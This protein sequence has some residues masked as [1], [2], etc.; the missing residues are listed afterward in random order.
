MVPIK[1]GSS[2][3]APL[4]RKRRSSAPNN[5]D[6]HSSTSDNDFS[7]SDNDFST[8]DNDYSTS[9]N[10]SSTIDNDSSPSDNDDDVSEYLPNRDDDPIQYHGWGEEETNTHENVSKLIGGIEENIRDGLSLQSC[11]EISTDCDAFSLL[12]VIDEEKKITPLTKN[13][14]IHLLSIFGTRWTPITIP[15]AP[16]AMHTNFR[17]RKDSMFGSQHVKMTCESNLEE[18][19]CFLVNNEALIIDTPVKI[20]VHQ[21]FRDSLVNGFNEK[22][23]P[24]ELS[25]NKGICIDPYK[26][27]ALPNYFDTLNII[28]DNCYDPRTKKH[29][30]HIGDLG[31]RHPV[32]KEDDDGFLQVMFERIHQLRELKTV[33]VEVCQ[34]DIAFNIKLGKKLIRW[35]PARN[36]QKEHSSTFFNY[37]N[38]SVFP[39]HNVES[40]GEFPNDKDQKGT[41]QFKHRN[42]GID[43]EKI[44]LV[45]EDEEHKSILSQIYLKR[46]KQEEGTRMQEEE[47]EGTRMQE[48]EGTRMH[49]EEEEGTRMLEEEQEHTREQENEEGARMQE[50]EETG[51]FTICSNIYDLH[52]I[53]FYSTVIHSLPTQTQYKF[54]KDGRDFQHIPKY[55]IRRIKDLLSAIMDFGFKGI[56]QI[57]NHGV[58]GRIEFSVRPTSHSRDLRLNGHL[59]DFLSIMFHSSIGIRSKELVALDYL[60]HEPVTETIYSLVMSVKGALVCRDSTTFDVFWK[61]HPNRCVWLTAMISLILTLSGYAHPCKTRFVRQW[62]K[63]EGMYD[64]MGVK[65]KIQEGELL[66][67]ESVQLVQQNQ[68]H[69]HVWITL[70]FILQ[71]INVSQQGIDQMYN[72]ISGHTSVGSTFRNLRLEDNLKLAE[73]ML[74]KIIPAIQNLIDQK[75]GDEGSDGE[76]QEYTQ[77]HDHMDFEDDQDF[78]DEF[79]DSVHDYPNSSFIPACD[80]A[81][82]LITQ[83]SPNLCPKVKSFMKNQPTQ[84]PIESVMS[85]LA[86]FSESLSPGAPG[87]MNRMCNFIGEVFPKTELKNYSHGNDLLYVD[88]Y[89]AATILDLDTQ[90]LRMTEIVMK[91]CEHSLFPCI[92]VKYNLSLLQEEEIESRRR[93]LLSLQNHVH[94]S[95]LRSDL[96]GHK[97]IRRHGENVDVY[98][99]E[100]EKVTQE[101]VIVNNTLSDTADSEF[102]YEN[103]SI[104]TSTLP[105]LTK[106]FND[107]GTPIQSILASSRLKFIQDLCDKFIHPTGMNHPHFNRYLTV[108][109]LI[110]AIREKKVKQPTIIQIFMACAAYHRQNNIAYADIPNAKFILFLYNLHTDKVILI[111]RTIPEGSIILPKVECIHVEKKTHNNVQVSQ[112]VLSNGSKEVCLLEDSARME[113]RNITTR[114]PRLREN[115]DK[116]PHKTKSFGTAITSILHSM[117]PLHHVSGGDDEFDHISNLV[118]EAAGIGSELNDMFDNSLISV[119]NKGKV[120]TWDD[121]ANLLPKYQG[122]KKINAST[123][124]QEK[125]THT[126]LTASIICFKYK[127]CIAIYCGATRSNDAETHFIYFHP[128]KRKVCL[129]EEK[130]FWFLVYHP[131]FIYIR[132]LKNEFQYWDADQKHRLQ[133]TRKNFFCYSA[134]HH[135]LMIRTRTKY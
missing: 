73:H 24:V 82:E 63:K 131:Q 46:E 95:T 71:E 59:V 34:L 5:D 93:I 86:E 88:L 106:L 42:W 115:Q 76:N 111:P 85:I 94:V 10:D 50:E 56:T 84:D 133:T 65:K 54:P 23:F 18:E 27:R 29:I 104:H 8:S 105:A 31:T 30:I 99:P 4:P 130:G 19:N 61:K 110:N 74:A 117:D 64:P 17:N 52:S 38:L 9:D 3:P 132:F 80:N 120:Q 21:N 33:T 90:H 135:T 25:S 62:M 98:I 134:K 114:H 7:T 60:D 119:L 123:E 108:E 70:L 28:L 11:T 44:A 40:E 87:F 53:K 43:D 45:E 89:N 96:P 81:I 78:N 102:L 6:S 2:E 129:V 72:L 32:S 116:P 66:K 26:T 125:F 35:Y 91:L 15:K 22:Q 128:F 13:R 67:N 68:D 122:R 48:E 109:S 121:I 12:V 14:I 92:N 20:A 101:V 51:N 37:L 16:V 126:I 124:T 113:I 49:E 100:K 79:L 39:L 75:I 77:N 57:Q 127:I 97:L 118:H 83:Q 58:M 69:N 1:R 36:K 55:N 112:W 103:K 107:G 47:E 41:I